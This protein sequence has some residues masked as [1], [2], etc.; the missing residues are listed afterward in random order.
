[1]YYTNKGIKN[2]A[3]PAQPDKPIIKVDVKRLTAA[4]QV[5]AVRAAVARVGG[6]EAAVGFRDALVARRAHELVKA[7]ARPLAC[8]V[9]AP[10]GHVGRELVWTRPMV[11]QMPL[12]CYIATH[13]YIVRH[14]KAR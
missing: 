7:A 13:V 14:L 6:E 5:R 8:R 9:A 10:A 1:M 2:L 4:Q 12:F 3:A 11:L